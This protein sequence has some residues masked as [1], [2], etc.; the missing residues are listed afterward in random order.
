MDAPRNKNLTAE[1]LQS[2]NIPR[3]VKRVL[4]RTENTHR[5]LMH[6]KAFAMDYVGLETDGA[7]W[8]VANT[9][10]KLVGMDYLSVAIES[11]APQVHRV[12]LAKGDLIPVEGL[13]LDDL[14]PGFYMLHCSPLRIPGADGSPTRCILMQ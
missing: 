9:D 6:Q 13:L 2:M 10:I 12:L 11:D 4:F 8:L 3:G 1:V 7:E 14:D 5:G